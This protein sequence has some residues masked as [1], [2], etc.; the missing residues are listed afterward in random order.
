MFLN[1]LVIVPTTKHIRGKLHVGLEIR[2][3]ARELIPSVFWGIILLYLVILQIANFQY[4]NFPPINRSQFN[5]SPANTNTMTAIIAPYHKPYERHR[6]VRS[7]TMSCLPLPRI[8][9]SLGKIREKKPRNGNLYNPAVM[10]V[11][12]QRAIEATEIGVLTTVIEQFTN[13]C[14]GAWY[15]LHTS[16]F[17]KIEAR[18]TRDTVRTPT[19]GQEQCRQDTSN[20]NYFG[21]TEVHT[22]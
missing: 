21:R 4:I 12:L 15:L 6:C 13:T 16:A 22:V 18:A 19:R 14:S 3:I 17:A 20:C 5:S 2:N 1:Y 11:I 7:V 10:Q 9:V 8:I